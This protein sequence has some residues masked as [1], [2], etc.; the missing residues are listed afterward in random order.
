MGADTIFDK[1]LRKDIP[2]DVLFENEHVLAIR[3]V[4]PQAPVHVLVL[5]K[6]RVERF[7]GL[8]AWQASD[9][10]E[11]FKAIAEVAAQLNLEERGYRIVV[12]NGRDGQQ[13]VEYL[14]AHIIGGR[15]LSWPPG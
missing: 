2:A 11:F 15:G 14:H 9:V 5:P 4:N 3:D 13:T 6:K 10:G 7:A 8:K 1:I 12:N